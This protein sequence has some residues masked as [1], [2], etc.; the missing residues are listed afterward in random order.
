M[1][2][3]SQMLLNTELFG[4]TVREKKAHFFLNANENGK[5]LGLLQ[6]ERLLTEIAYN[7]GKF[8]KLHL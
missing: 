1:T 5:T 3:M 8:L 7:A 2:E 4:T 6:G